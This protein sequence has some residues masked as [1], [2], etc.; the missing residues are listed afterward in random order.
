MPGVGVE[1]V[2]A[3][4]EAGKPVQIIDARPR[5]SMSRL[6]D[7]MDGA[8]WRDPDL[9]QEFR[10]AVDAKY[11]KGGHSVWKALGGAI[12]PHAVG[13]QESECRHGGDARCVRS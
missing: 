7:I 5:Q 1:E 13:T 8:A 9:V 2:K 4:L 3:M 6:Q 11:M 10:R 12:K